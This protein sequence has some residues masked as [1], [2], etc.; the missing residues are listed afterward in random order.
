MRLDISQVAQKRFLK[1][2]Y[3]EYP[4]LKNKIKTSIISTSDDKL[5]FKDNFFDFIH[6]NQTIY[7]LPSEKAIRKLI[8]EWYRVL[9]PGGRIMFST[10]GP[11]NSTIKGAVEI[12][13]N[14]FEKWYKTPNMKKPVKLRS[15]LMKD[16]NAIRKLCEPS[17]EI[18]EIG[19]FTSHYC[20]IDGFHW[21]I[22]ARK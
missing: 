20:G 2:L 6:S 7:H 22:F 18:E 1:M 10:V 4:N 21:Q 13:K 14:L 9:K 8:N 16:E 5:P 19:W 11:E 17:F 3:N 15:Y 12:E